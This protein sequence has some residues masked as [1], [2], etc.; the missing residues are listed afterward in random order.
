MGCWLNSLKD[1]GSLEKY[2]G[3]QCARFARV[4]LIYE[5]AR[6]SY[7]EFR[8]SFHS[9]APSPPGEASQL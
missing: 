7:E 5:E 4:A 3:R 8:V 9:E 1:L 6:C 2:N